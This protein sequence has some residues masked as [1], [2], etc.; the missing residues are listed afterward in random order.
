MRW[1]TLL[2]TTIAWGAEL[3]ITANFSG[4]KLGLVQRV[5][6]WHWRVGVKGQSDQDG[7]NRQANW[8]SFRVDGAR[9]GREIVIDLVDLPGE[10]N[11]EKN[12]GAVTR[13]TRPY[14]REKGEKAAWTEVEGDYDPSEPKWRLRFNPKGSSFYVA[15][16]EPYLAKD[17]DALRKAVNPVVEVIGKS[18]GGRKIEVWTI[19]R[20]GAKPGAPVVWLMFRQ[21]AWEAGSSWTGDGAIR[22]LPDGIVWKILPSSDP[23]GVAEGGVRFNHHG[24]DLNRNWDSPYDAIKRPE[25]LAQKKALESWLETGNK[26]D[27]FLTV[28]NTETGEY[29]EGPPEGQG[30]ELWQAL[31]DHSAFD[32]NREY[33]TRMEVSGPGRAN[34]IQWLWNDKRVQAHLMEL[35]IAR[36]PKLE[37]RPT[38]QS[39]QQFGQQL[40]KE[41]AAVLTQPR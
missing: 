39:W 36:S 26:I 34:V 31:K 8:Y 30:K 27:F 17:L 7:R 11:Y 16:L 15:H 20:S 21:H 23:D 37:A 41:I 24:Y 32:P 12:Q 14:W 13:D 9:R 4:G 28:H 22:S 6:P 29:L 3:K 40:A 10:Y 5:S 38:A 2:L 25:I 19:D 1:L 33:F 35:R 18:A